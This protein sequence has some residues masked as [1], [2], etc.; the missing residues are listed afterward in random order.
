MASDFLGMPLTRAQALAAAGV[1]VLA[2]DTAVP[3]GETIAQGAA[4]AA[5]GPKGAPKHVATAKGA[6]HFHAGIGGLIIPHGMHYAAGQPGH[7]IGN[8]SEAKW[9][10]NQWKD[11]DKASEAAEH[12]VAAGTHHWV[13]AG[14]HSY[15]VHN[16]LE[17]HIP[18]DTDVH[19]AA[20]VKNAPKVVVKHGDHPEHV[21][22]KPEGAGEVQDSTAGSKHLLAQGYKKLPPQQPKK[23]VTFEGKQAA[24]VP[25][26]WQVYKSTSPESQIVTKFAK[27]PEGNWH[28]IHKGGQV[29]S[30]YTFPHLEKWAAA[31]SIVPDEHH[32]PEPDHAVPNQGAEGPE[33]AKAVIGG[34]AVTK[35]EIHSAIQHLQEDKS[36]AVK[37]PLAKKGHPLAAMD[38]HAVAQAELK[39]HPELKVPAGTKK[40]HVGQVKLAVL[41]HLAA[42]ADK[43]AADEAQAKAAAEAKAKAEAAA[44]HAQQLTPGTFDIGGVTATGEHIADAIKHLEAA[45]STA[46]K[47]ILKAKGNPLADSDY[48]KVIKEY[49]AAHPAA[50]QHGTKQAHVANAKTKYIAALKEKSGQAAQVDQVS[51]HDVAAQLDQI[52]TGPGAQ[53]KTGWSHSADG[54]MAAALLASATGGKHDQYAYLSNVPGEW[55]VGMFPPENKA[56]IKATPEHVL[57]MVLA[58]GKEDHDYAPQHA[59]DIAKQWITTEAATPAKVVPEPQPAGVVPDVGKPTDYE[60]FAAWK[61]AKDK[62]EDQLAD[63]AQAQAAA[64]AQAFAEWKASLDYQVIDDLI[65]N[66]PGG[67]PPHD[68]KLDTGQQLA[69]MLYM[70]AKQHKTWY[71]YSADNGDWIAVK[72]LPPGYAGT[73]GMPGKPWY[74]VDEDHQITSYDTHSQ[75]TAIPGEYAA[76]LAKQW[77]VPKQPEPAKP[78]AG[79][80]V[81]VWVTGQKAGEVPAGSKIYT[82][83][84][85]LNPV[86]AVKYV[87]K[88][89]GSWEHWGPTGNGMYHEV[90]PAGSKM[91]GDWDEMLANGEFQVVSP[92]PAAAG[93][94]IPVIV[95]GENKGTVPAGSKFY[96]QLHPTTDAAKASVYVKKPD[97][98]WS[99]Y[100]TKGMVAG[101]WDSQLAAGNY[102][103]IEPPSGPAQESAPEMIS[104]AGN[105][106]GA[107]SKVYKYKTGEWPKLVQTPAGDWHKVLA[108]GEAKK[109]TPELSEIFN[110]QLS[111]GD[112][113]PVSGEQAAGPDI[114]LAVDGISVGT[115]PAGSQI[116]VHKDFAQNPEN[117]N[118]F[119]KLP[120][121]SWKTFWTD[122]GQPDTTSYPAGSKGAF[123][124]EAFV[125]DGTWVLYQPGKAAAEATPEPEKPVIVKVGAKT[126]QA[127]AGSKV[128][129]WNPEK[130]SGGAYSPEHVKYVEEPDGTWKSVFAST[131]VTTIPATTAA[132]V[133]M[134]NLVPWTG[135][136]PAE[137]AE[138]AKPAGEPVT[139]EAG[140]ATYQAPAGSKVYV[141]AQDKIPSFGASSYLPENVKYVEEPGGIWK[142]VEAGGVKDA[143]Q[144]P[145]ITSGNLVPWTGGVAPEVAEPASPAG[146]SATVEAG[147]TTYQAPAGSKVYVWAKDKIPSYNAASLAPDQLKYIEEPDGSWKQVSGAGVKTAVSQAVGITSGK[148]VPWT[149]D[150]EPS[151]ETK[152]LKKLLV[153]GAVTPSKQLEEGKASQDWILVTTLQKAAKKGANQWAVKKPDGAWYS[154]AYVP[155]PDAEYYKVAPD[156][157]VTHHAADGTETPVPPEKVA[158]LIHQLITPD[159]VKLQVFADG[160]YQYKVFKHGFYYKPSKQAKAYLEIGPPPPGSSVSAT[161]TYHAP[162]G[163]KTVNANYAGKVLQDATDYYPQPKAAAPGT[164]KV[165]HAT[166]SKPGTYQ[167]W[168]DIT[169]AP[170]SEHT[171]DLHEDGSVLL[172]NPAGSSYPVSAESEPEKSLLKGGVLLDQYGTSMVKPGMPTEAYHVFGSEAKTP[173]Q[174]KDLLNQFEHASGLG[175]YSKLMAS[176]FPGDLADRAVQFFGDKAAADSWQGQRDAVMALL[177]ELLQVPGQPAGAVAEPVFLKSLPPGI[178]SAKDVFTWTDQ[179]YAAPAEDI[180]AASY[181]MSNLHY[182]NASELSDMIKQV[183][184]QFGGGKVVG[185]H[186][187]S[188]TKDQKAAWLKAWLAGDMTKV[189]ALDAAGGKVSPAHPGA[190]K[191]EATHHITW[192]PWDPSQIPA[193]QAI[194]GDWSPE[195]VLSPKA[196]VDNY[197]I[198]AGLQHAEWLTAKQRREWMT[199]HRAHDQLTVDKLSKQAADAFSSGKQPQTEPPKW[200]DNL[201]PAKPYD[202]YLDEKTPAN[203][204]PS[205]AV[206]AFVA[207]H[208]ADISPFVKPAAGEYGAGY[209]SGSYTVDELLAPGFYYHNYVKKGAIQRYLDDLAAKE[210]AEKLKPRYNLAQPDVAEDQFGRQYQWITGSPADLARRVAVTQLARLWGFRTPQAS[211]VLLED[212]TVGAIVPLLQPEGTLAFLPAGIAGLTNRELG[213]VASE[214][215]LDYALANPASTPG[216]YLRMADGSIIGTGKPLALVGLH[217]DGTDPAGMNS[218]SVQPVSLIFAAI[219]DGTLSQDQADA[220]YLAAVRTAR[221]MSALPDARLQALLGSTIHSADIIT[222]LTDRKNELPAVI[223]GM[224][225]GVYAARGWTP[226]PVPVSKITRGLHSGFSEPEFM[227]HVAA[228]KS[229]GVPAFFNEPGLASGNIHV[230]TELDPEGS[231]LVRGEATIRGNSLDKVTGWIKAHSGE[232]AAMAPKDETKFHQAIKKAAE[233]IKT[234]AKDQLWDGPITSSALAAMA[235]AKDGLQQQLTDAQYALTAGPASSSYAQVAK[236]YGDPAAVV[237]MAQAYLAQIETAEHAKLSGGDLNPAQFPAWTP[238]E[239]AH[240]LGGGVKITYKKSSRELGT[241]ADQ[242]TADTWSLGKDDG[243]LRLQHGMS[244]SYPGY[245]WEVELPTGEK[246]DI[247][248]ESQTQTPKA[249]HGMMRFTAVTADGAASLERIRAFLQ[250]AGLDMTE[251]SQADMENLYW[252]QLAWVLA[253][254]ADR[255]DPKY[256]KVWDEL[257]QGLYG[258]TA[259]EVTGPGKPVTYI[260]Q[261]PAQ[262]VDKHMVPEEEAQLWR[263]AWAHLTSDAQVQQW[264]DAEGYLPHLGHFD[265]H[266]PQVPGGKPEWYRFDLNPADVAAQQ[267]VTEGFYESAKDAA[268]IARSGGLYSSDARLRA[269]GTYKTGMSWGSDMDKGSSGTVFTRQNMQS[270]TGMGAWISPRVLARVRTYTFGSDMFG[271]V[272]AR[273]T[274]SYFDFAKASAHSGSGNEAM[275][276]DGISLLDDIEVLKA[277]SE[278]QRQQIIADLKHA[279]ITEIRGLPVEDRIV[280]SLGVQAAIQKAIAAA[281]SAGWFLQPEE[282][283]VP[284]PSALSGMTAAQQKYVQQVVK[285]EQAMDAAQEAATAAQQIEQLAQGVEAPFSHV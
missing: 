118:K 254:R 120:D 143:S 191:N 82:G 88:P 187:S 146:E 94:D 98:A 71:L 279:G 285:E 8:V 167:M 149:P 247:N 240:L 65:K 276:S 56:S 184:A 109:A 196:E 222:K 168:S 72:S 70:A 108:H 157:E 32:G 246:I 265:I 275:I 165:T 274:S 77:L 57:T 239:Q 266:A 133:K 248:D 100:G 19:D 26:D 10:A 117:A 284:P 107:G 172:H 243:E 238:V 208:K 45:K 213:D 86:T 221:R 59:L 200:T 35:D 242:I 124:L 218:E 6:Q 66:Y 251:A 182:L 193:S 34:V 21:M 255:K 40:A 226:P 280:T 263:T 231:R 102:K 268:L 271:E 83:V 140:G 190:P 233:V 29:T 164:L 209:A 185:T 79:P 84:K 132:A 12:A 110:K 87:K 135:G 104:V 106:F 224:W 197:L 220:A 181:Q 189:F 4:A 7:V 257:A 54:A 272:D 138:P 63:A 180:L 37:Q 225:D 177:R 234:H 58:G 3:A 148:I 166:V 15:A 269:L 175:G 170:S 62:A 173:E 18:K 142:T 141:W 261:L 30:A 126:Y 163:S 235:D 136:K 210:A 22:L 64:A 25:H 206:S 119:A 67:I 283:Y 160:Q 207:D 236:D 96:K 81:P 9:I 211:Q 61:A 152:D 144:D 179:G 273:R 216:S 159:A 199:A 52:I 105:A 270:Q 47:Q 23:A 249:Q 50:A 134:G 198:K 202:A 43:M 262:V 36:T 147:G 42:Q 113:V 1:L 49:E 97:G 39:A 219:G 259:G 204:W 212:G 137:S 151:Q 90:A 171:A 28:A 153:N 241:N 195:G 169:K 38:Y 13:Q 256:L 51:G 115:V 227:D 78:A 245:V 252:R 48:W 31:G 76:D 228:A 74:A 277:Y 237:S 116:Y 103:E 214:H 174:V 205:E 46:I 122:D 114:P 111:W 41:H 158:G 215:V 53:V 14:E 112:L 27:D 2:Y 16:G 267:L 178:Q 155:Y 129:V 278:T 139:V 201:V 253:D 130:M 123:Q 20:A 75:P 69:A 128:Y 244:V 217:W 282:A 203:D 99:W 176:T 125:Q 264:V 281:D 194:E 250:Q 17:V 161:Y 33:P 150:M 223:Q 55:T 154:A 24:W 5:G 89:D 95:G 127:P 91:A 232:A 92:Q 156:L 162:S 11:K 192:A 230:W 44:D 101:N 60:N 183:S 258:K 131:G 229:F 188:L 186:I 80:P 121:G 145:A 85:A 73:Y 93:P 68:N 260:G